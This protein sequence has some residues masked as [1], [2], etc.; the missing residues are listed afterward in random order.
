[1]AQLE[2]FRLK[3]FRSVAEQLSFRKAAERMF[4]SQPAVTLQIK[5]LEE[6]L[7]VRLFDRSGGKVALTTQGAILLGHA[8]KIAAIASQAETQIS[9][10]NGQ[11][12]G[13][14]ALGVS[15]TIAQ[16][17]LPRLL[18]VFL[19]EH[20]RVELSFHSGNTDA[21]VQLLLA[22]KISIGLVAGPAR[23]RGVRVE[24]FMEDELVLIVP[25]DFE[26]E[27]L[28]ARQLAA[29]TLLLREPGSGSRQAVEAA[30]RTAGLRTASFKS[31]I[32]LDSTEAIKSAVE[33]GL[34]IG[35]VS[36]YAI[37]KEMELQD[38]KVVPIEGLRVTRHYF[39]ASL[40]GPEPSGATGAFRRFALDRAKHLAEARPKFEPRRRKR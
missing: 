16:Y 38:I 40:V 3:V 32:E 26:S 10:D 11:L 39:V 29:S 15:T 31:L 35:F 4:L 30:L 18:A 9:A 33:A 27:E 21:I 19:A 17:V 14:F 25:P 1:M 7:G 12:S 28:S 6:E 24:P 2:N 8:Q 34:G 13:I 20:P 36:Q 22:G 37:K 23:Q 5:A